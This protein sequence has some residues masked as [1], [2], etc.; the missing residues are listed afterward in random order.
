MTLPHLHIRPKLQT[1]FASGIW[2][3]D[4]LGEF[5]HKDR[6]SVFKLTLFCS[7]TKLSKF[8]LLF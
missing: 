3:E 8:G 6:I 7:E 1:T 2:V 5:M 4:A